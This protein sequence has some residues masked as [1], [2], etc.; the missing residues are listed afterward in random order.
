MHRRYIAKKL[1]V[2]PPNSAW[3]WA[4]HQN[5]HNRKRRTLLLATNCLGIFISF[6]SNSKRRIQFLILLD[7][8]HSGSLLKRHPSGFAST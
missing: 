1:S 8:V 6:E 5:L 7:P 3:Q 2:S 4:L